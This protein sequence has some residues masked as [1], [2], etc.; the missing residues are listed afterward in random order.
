MKIAYIVISTIYMLLAF[1]TKDI[2]Y[3]LGAIWVLKMFKL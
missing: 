1:S 2:T 3:A